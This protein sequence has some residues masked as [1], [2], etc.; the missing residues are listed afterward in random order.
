MPVL[1]YAKQGTGKQMGSRALIA[2][3]KETWMCSDLSLALLIGVCYALF[4][5]W[6]ADSV[7]ALVMPPVIAWQGWETLTEAASTTLKS[8]DPIHQHRREALAPIPR[9]RL[10]RRIS[11]SARSGRHITDTTAMH[12]CT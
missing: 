7:G 2:N 6:R 1:A 12:T 10:P 8:T 4:D 3:S 11:A 5:W 9:R